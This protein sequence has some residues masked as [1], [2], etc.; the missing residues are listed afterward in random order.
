M[1]AHQR[2]ISPLAARAIEA[3]DGLKLIGVAKTFAAGQEV[4]GE[5]DTAVYAFKV[6][7]GAARAVRLLADGRRQIVEFYLPGDVFGIELGQIRRMTVEA[8]GDAVLVVAR[9]T[10]LTKDAERLWR[11]AFA[12]LVRAENHLLTLGRRSASERLASFLTDLAARIGADGVVE[13]PMSRQDI[14]DHL[15]LTIETVSRTLT[16]LQGQGVVEARG[17]R[18]VRLTHPAALAELCE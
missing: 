11:H 1:H 9:R 14:A 10:T 3:D 17:C 5:G 13:L 2:M 15:G 16:Q 12:A 6:A 7:S 4:F 18:S 8:V